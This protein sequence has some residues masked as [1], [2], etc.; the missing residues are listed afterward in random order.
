MKVICVVCK[1]K[2]DKEPLDQPNLYSAHLCDECRKERE[3]KSKIID[4]GLD[5]LWLH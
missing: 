2:S 4:H 5:H 1:K 3:D